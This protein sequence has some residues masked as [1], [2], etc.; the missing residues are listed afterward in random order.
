MAELEVRIERLEPTRVVS[1]HGFGRDPERQAY[2]LLVAWARPR[3]LLDEPRS[4]R[5]FGFDNPAPSPGSPNHGYELWLTVGPEVEPDGDIELE[6]LPGGLY[7]VTRV[8]G[9]RTIGTGWRQLVAWRESSPFRCACHQCLEE[10]IG[11][12]IETQDED[13]V[14]L[15]LLLPIAE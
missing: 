6:E 2:R 13:E 1:V 3:G 7:A 4:G 9:I 14:V 10:H 5:I 11:P 8:T 15:D 12:V